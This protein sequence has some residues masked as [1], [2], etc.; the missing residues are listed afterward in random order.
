MGSP[1]FR[2][3]GSL[4][5]RLGCPGATSHPADHHRNRSRRSGPSGV[6]HRSR[7]IVTTNAIMLQHASMMNSARSAFVCER[8]VARTH[9]PPINASNTRT[10]S[11]AMNESGSS[12]TSISF[13]P[14]GPTTSV[15]LTFAMRSGALSAHAS[16]RR[17]ARSAVPPPPSHRSDA[18]PSDLRGCL[19]F[20]GRQAPHCH[21]DGSRAPMRPAPPSR[22]CTDPMSN[23]PPLVHGNAS[24]CREPARRARTISH[25]SSVRSLACDRRTACALGSAAVVAARASVET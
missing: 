15:F 8:T 23:G 12:D 9:M 5:D 11:R 22:G 14:S 18:M 16:S 2:S 19:G 13:R 25:S 3:A 17:E 1:S 4:V 7:A 6:T 21:N 24:L 20:G 10:S